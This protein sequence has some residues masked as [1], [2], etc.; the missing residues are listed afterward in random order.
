MGEIL[1]GITQRRSRRRS[2]WAIHSLLLDDRLM[3]ITMVNWATPSSLGVINDCLYCFHLETGSRSIAPWSIS[4]PLHETLEV[5]REQ[6]LST[7][8]IKTQSTRY[9]RFDQHESTNAPTKTDGLL[10]SFKNLLTGSTWGAVDKQLPNLER[11]DEMSKSRSTSQKFTVT[12]RHKSEFRSQFGESPLGYGN[13]IFAARFYTFFSVCHGLT[14]NFSFPTRTRKGAC[15]ASW[16]CC[17]NRINSEPRTN[18]LFIYQSISLH[19]A[20]AE[21]VGWLRNRK[22]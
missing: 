9:A 10:S 22:Y 4:W 3:A 18:K 17:T 8:F 6:N 5:T 20:R 16:I 19:L 15:A 2:Q 21:P 11:D 14:A 13:Q 12:K 1:K 7:T